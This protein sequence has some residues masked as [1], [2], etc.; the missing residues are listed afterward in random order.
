MKK[1]PKIGAFVLETLTTG[2]YTNPLDTLREYIQN[3]S[4]SIRKAEQSKLL[5]DGEG[6]VEIRIF[7]KE[8]RLVMRDNGMGIPAD[9]AADRLVNIGMSEKD[10]GTDAG[11]RGIGRLA[12]IAYCSTLTFRTTASGESDVTVVSIDCGRVREAISPALRGSHELTEV[13]ADCSDVRSEAGTPTEHFLEVIMEGV[14]TSSA[15]FLNWQVLEQY[16][17][18]IGACP[19]FS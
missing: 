9:V 4:D 8:R 1:T 3:S 17:S 10:I 14:D 18:Q 16:L 19:R 15:D 12:G 6:R 7:P 11:F 2:M 5:R 13:F